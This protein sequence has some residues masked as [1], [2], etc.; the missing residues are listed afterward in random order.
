MSTNNT[1]TK[2]RAAA[3]KPAQT[4][5]VQIGGDE[6]VTYHAI[7]TAAPADYDGFGTFEVIRYNDGTELR[8][9]TPRMVRVVLVRAEHLNWQTARYS[10]GMFAATPTVHDVE[11]IATELWKRLQGRE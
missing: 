4:I 10:S 11:H 2:A 3:V 8:D 5:K 6:S 7:D 1:D 9:G